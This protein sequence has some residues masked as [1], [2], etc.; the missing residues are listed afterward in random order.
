VHPGPRSVVRRGSAAGP[1]KERYSAYPKTYAG[2]CQK[3]MRFTRLGGIEAAGVEV[4]RCNACKSAPCL[5]GIMP[6]YY[7]RSVKKTDPRNFPRNC[8]EELLAPLRQVQARTGY[9]DAFNYSRC[10]CRL[11]RDFSGLFF[12][13]A[14]TLRPPVLGRRPFHREPVPLYILG[15]MPK[16]GAF[17]PVRGRRQNQSEPA[18]RKDRGCRRQGCCPA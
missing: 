6:T 16:E 13:Q 12:I 15:P 3:P 4:L 9:F 18:Q 5:E 2:L 14:H 10:V 11:A 17:T 7:Y 1:P 8:Q